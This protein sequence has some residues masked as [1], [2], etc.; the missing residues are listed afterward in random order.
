MRILAV[1]DSHGETEELRWL[2]DEIRREY[3]AM[4]IFIHCGDGSTDLRRI[5]PYLLKN[6]PG[7]VMYT[8]SGNCDLGNDLPSDLI[9]EFDGTRIFVTHGHRYGV[10]TSLDDLDRK[11][12]SERC[13]LALYGHTHIANWEM[14][15]VLLVNPGS[16]IK[17][18]AAMISL[19]N[20]N[21]N[22]SLLE[23]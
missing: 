12:S 19:E 15:S 1:S 7:A 10:K 23:Y 16:A 14:K 22:A 20:G 6:N 21:V 2:F 3:G 8:V 13:S 9:L 5:Q 11:A 18:R 17:G 4:D